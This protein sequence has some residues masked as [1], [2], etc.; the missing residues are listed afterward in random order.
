MVHSAFPQKL[1]KQFS[2]RVRFLCVALVQQLG[3]DS[4]WYV[5][6]DAIWHW[7]MPLCMLLLLLICYVRSFFLYF[8]LSSI[9]KL[10]G[11]VDDT[12]MS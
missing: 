6:L 4:R 3:D 5:Q 8:S 12:S 11:T 10:D 2:V 1:L 9:D 7:Y